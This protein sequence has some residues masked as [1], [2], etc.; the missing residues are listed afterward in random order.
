M[1][2]AVPEFLDEP[3]FVFDD[4]EGKVYSCILVF[5]SGKGRCV[6]PI[7]GLHSGLGVD[8]AG[9]PMWFDLFAYELRAV[10]ALV[11][12]VVRRWREIEE[13]EGP[14]D[15]RRALTRQRLERIL[16]A[17]AKAVAGLSAWKQIDLGVAA[18]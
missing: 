5:R 8:D 14:L 16:A 17:V 6:L 2:D 4:V 10:P 3:A 9:L 1:P 18:R 12:E 11:D 13:R 15:E 7:E